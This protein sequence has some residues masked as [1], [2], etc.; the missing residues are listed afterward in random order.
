MATDQQSISSRTGA[1]VL[2][3]GT[4]AGGGEGTT[5]GGTNKASG[6]PLGLEWAPMSAAAGVTSAGNVEGAVAGASGEKRGRCDGTA[7]GVGCMGLVEEATLAACGR[8]RGKWRP[9]TG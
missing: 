5:V 9:G 7:D 6:A 3:D 2:G 4:G 1:E 8:E